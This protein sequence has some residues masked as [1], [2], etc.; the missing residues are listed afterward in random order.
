M[1][2]QQHLHFTPSHMPMLALSPRCKSK[3]SIKL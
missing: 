2:S 1:R 3:T